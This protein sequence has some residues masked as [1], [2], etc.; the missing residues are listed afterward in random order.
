[1]LGKLQTPILLGLTAIQALCFVL[2]KAGLAYAPPLLFGG[3]RA[4]VGGSVL[5]GLMI[6]LRQPLLPPRETWG[7]LLALALTA[8]TLGFGGMFLSPGRTGAGIASVLGNI[9]PLIL[10]GLA[11]AF[12]GERMTPRRWIT[13]A[14]GLAGVILISWEARA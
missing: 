12:L 5:F 14:L 4:L 8:T 10:V 1:M 2:I 9:Q 7:G 6:V 13:V 11:A 3:L